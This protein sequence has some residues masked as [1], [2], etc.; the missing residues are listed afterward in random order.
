MYGKR[1]TFFINSLSYDPYDT[2]LLKLYGL[3]NEEII[4]QLKQIYE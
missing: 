2:Q 1:I 4:E 3:S